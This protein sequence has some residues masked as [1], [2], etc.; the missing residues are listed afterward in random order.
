MVNFLLIFFYPGPSVGSATTAGAGTG[1]AC[2]ARAVCRRVLAGKLYSGILARSC[3]VTTEFR[4]QTTRCCSASR[5]RQ[6]LRWVFHLTTQKEGETREAEIYCIFLKSF[7]SS[8]FGICSHLFISFFLL[9]SSISTVLF[10]VVISSNLGI[11]SICR[12]WSRQAYKMSN[13]DGNYKR[14]HPSL[15]WQK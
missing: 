2:S 11:K 7:F 9:L 1:R 5:N 14:L 15:R 10:A 6:C 3:H 4:P 8:F 13:F 12:D